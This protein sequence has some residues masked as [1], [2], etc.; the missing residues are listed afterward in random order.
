MAVK[1]IR[2]IG[3]IIN[4]LVIAAL[5]LL[6]VL[7]SYAIWDNGETVM[8]GSAKTYEMYKPDEDR[9]G[10]GGRGFDEMQAINPEV[11]AWITIYGTDIDYPITQAE[12]NWKYINTDAFGE[13]AVTGNIFLDARNASD[14]SDFNNITYGHN[15]TPAVMYGSIKEFKDPVFFDQ[16]E[17]GDLYYGGKHH[18]IEIIAMLQASGY[19]FNVFHAPITDDMEREAYR[20][21]IEQES[22]HKRNVYVTTED[23]LLLMSTCSNMETNER[24]ILIG[25]IVDETFENTFTD[26]AESFAGVAGQTLK[27]MLEEIPLAVWIIMIAVI[28]LIIFAA[29]VGRKKNRNKDDQG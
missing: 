10:L 21:N 22:I 13:Y 15:M 5:I 2:I 14:F 16:H 9:A 29:T 20:Y 1:T 26:E 23:H 8:R 28:L 3:N 12:D 25:R 4:W 7:G 19:D 17:Y 24:N 27:E 18:G 11:V 6:M